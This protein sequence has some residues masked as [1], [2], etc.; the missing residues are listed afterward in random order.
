MGFGNPPALSED[1][2]VVR[3]SGKSHHYPPSTSAIK[4]VKI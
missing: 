3:E 4:R 1:E 2:K